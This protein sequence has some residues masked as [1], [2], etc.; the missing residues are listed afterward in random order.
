MS[1]KEGMEGRIELDQVEGRGK[2]I[3]YHKLKLQENCVNHK[4][5]KSN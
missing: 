4:F 2:R 3:D 1:F 5:D